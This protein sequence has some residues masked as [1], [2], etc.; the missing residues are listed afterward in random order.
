MLSLK[1]LVMND[2]TGHYEANPKATEYCKIQPTATNNLYASDNLKSIIGGKAYSLISL[3]NH[4]CMVP[5]TW[6]IPCKFC[7]DRR[8]V[9][10]RPLVEYY[11]Y[12]M[13]NNKKFAV[14]SGAP[15]SMPGLMQTKLN[16][17]F[18]DIQEAI[19]SVWDSWN[20]DHAKMYREA[21]GID[22]NLGTA[23][24]IQEM[25]PFQKYAGVA[26][27][28]NPADPVNR[29]DFDPIIEYVEGLGDALVGG[30]VQPT[31]MTTTNKSIYPY[32]ASTLEEL[33]NR[34]GA[35]DIEWAY[36]TT[37]GMYFLQMRPL[38][39]ATPPELAA[40][41][42]SGRKAITFGK[43]I[44]GQRRVICKVIHAN[45]VVNNKL[46]EGAAVYVSE[47]RPKYYPLMMASRSILC[48]TGGETCHAAIIAREFDKPAISCI[49]Y[50]D[51]KAHNLILVD[52]GSGKIYEALD[53]DSVAKDDSNKTKVILDNSRIPNLGIKN[54]SP[55]SYSFNVNSL[56]YRFYWLLNEQL[57]GKITV[58]DR[59]A[60]VKEIA[61]VLAAYLY[62]ATACEMRYVR[63]NCESSKKRRLVIGALRFLGLDITYDQVVKDRDQFA[64]KIPQPLTIEQAALTSKWVARGFN[65]LTWR[66]GSF[67]GK[68][69][70]QIADTISNYLHGLYTPVMFVD[71][72]FNLQHNGG[73]VF[74]KFN[75]LQNSSSTLQVQL[76]AKAKSFK[77]LRDVSGYYHNQE[78][79][80]TIFK[81]G[82]KGLSWIPQVKEELKKEVA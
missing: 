48:S 24:I 61:D 42:D 2:Y 11:G 77:K 17:K 39:F 60:K 57:L 32:L 78:T 80:T 8:E 65:E 4:G 21:K 72:T 69:W 44:G 7:I 1:S 28:A 41:D 33:H 38:K 25:V 20:T 15:V 76:D 35:V 70:G 64:I 58:E 71:T 73:C 27:S 40:N 36:S 67:G 54:G 63:R 79:I 19:T 68:K 50:E 53:N 10:L 56:L 34:F 3:H 14:R 49:N 62:T 22:H 45:D 26:F 37:H 66:G 18:E 55:S 29:M 31:R 75:W 30:E 5:K 51:I 74:G 43:S 47:F 9:D 12:G 59:D 6:V 81:Q 82:Y 46:P 16:V 13:E 23:V 52:G